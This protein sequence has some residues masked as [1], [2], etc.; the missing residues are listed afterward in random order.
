MSKKICPLYEDFGGDESL[1]SIEDY[2][3][4]ENAEELPSVEDFIEEEV[5]S[6]KLLP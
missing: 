2:I 4:E 1:P 3:T 5:I 6:E